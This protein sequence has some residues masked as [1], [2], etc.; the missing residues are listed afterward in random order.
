MVPTKTTVVQNNVALT[1]HKVRGL[2]F[3]VVFFVTAIDLI[4]ATVNN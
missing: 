4:V 3:K 2:Y 1:Y